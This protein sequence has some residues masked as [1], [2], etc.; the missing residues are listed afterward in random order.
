MKIKQSDYVTKTEYKNYDVYVFMNLK[1]PKVNIVYKYIDRFIRKIIN[2]PLRP[3]HT[4]SVTLQ[5]VDVI[6]VKKG[7]MKDETNK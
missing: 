2:K 7:E 4:V 5:F 6:L 3:K 1:H